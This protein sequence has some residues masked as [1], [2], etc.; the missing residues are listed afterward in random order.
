MSS[1]QR[2]GAVV[3][4]VVLIA[5]GAL[6]QTQSGCGKRE[7]NRS[8]P[9]LS[10]LDS[11][12]EALAQAARDERLVLADVRSDGCG[13]CDK[14]E[15]ETFTDARVAAKLATFTL[16]KI[17]FNRQ[18]D[19]ALQWGVRGTPTTVVLDAEGT[20]I[21]TLEGFRPPDDYLAFLNAIG[22]Q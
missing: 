20:V 2:R 8:G 22:Q 12:D 11:L 7:S 14:L 16:V 6:M 9:N 1:E 13:W 5:A 4:V 3:I 21:K 15:A 17:D 18:R 10:W 19:L